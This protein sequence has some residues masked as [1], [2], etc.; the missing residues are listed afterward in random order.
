[1]IVVL[2]VLVLLEAFV[3]ATSASI[4]LALSFESHRG[5][6]ILPTLFELIDSA[7]QQRPPMLSHNFRFWLSSSGLVCL[8]VFECALARF[9]VSAAASAKLERDVIQQQSRNPLTAAQR[10]Q[11]R[12]F[13]I[14]PLEVACLLACSV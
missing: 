6:S 9:C 4:T 3:L 12:R 14:Y 8:F 11:A 2:V 5:G 7:Y 1:M 10:D 13:N